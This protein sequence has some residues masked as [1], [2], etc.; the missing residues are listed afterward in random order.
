MHVRIPAGAI[1]HV[2]S[3]RRREVVFTDSLRR[4]TETAAGRLHELLASAQ[5]PPPVLHPKCKQCSL[6]DLC[7]PELISDLRHYR[8]T[9]DELFRVT[10]TGH[11]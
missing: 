9:A 2:K 10:E 11:G 6:H 3:K 5:T 4:Q 1:F 8:R 7:L